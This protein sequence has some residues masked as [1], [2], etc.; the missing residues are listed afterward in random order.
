MPQQD[1]RK[2]ILHGQQRMKILAE[3]IH[4]EPRH[5]QRGHFTHFGPNKLHNT[6]KGKSSSTAAIIAQPMCGI[7]SHLQQAI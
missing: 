6:I 5:T 7:T 1:S 4:Y 2:P 3:N